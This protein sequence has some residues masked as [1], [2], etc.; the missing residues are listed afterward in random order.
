MMVEAVVGKSTD[1]NQIV[2]KGSPPVSF[3]NFVEVIGIADGVKSIKA[4]IWTNFGDSI[5]MLL[6]CFIISLKCFSSTNLNGIC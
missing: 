1:K 6:P 2:M 4:E 3:T 5:G